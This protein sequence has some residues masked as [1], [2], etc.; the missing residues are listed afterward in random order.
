ML[1]EAW[2][3]YTQ[4]NIA[5]TTVFQARSTQNFD[6]EQNVSGKTLTA[7]NCRDTEI[8]GS[9]NFACVSKISQ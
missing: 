3:V 1:N 8:K 5:T 2:C 6:G 4:I 9:I 7:R